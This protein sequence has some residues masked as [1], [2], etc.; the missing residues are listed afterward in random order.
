MRILSFGAGVQTTALLFLYPERYDYVV[1]ADTGGE[2]ESTYDYINNHILPFCKKHN[3]QFVRV[4]NKYDKTLYEYC[5]DKKI[6][7]SM[8]YRDC[9]SKFK[10]APIRSF[11]RNVLKAHRKNPIFQDIGISYDEFWRSSV[12]N[13]Q[14]IINQYPLVDGKFTRPQLKRIIKILGYPC[15]QKSG[16]WFCPFAKEYPKE[17]L[18]KVIAL[19]ENNRRFPEILLRGMPSKRNKPLREM[20]ILDNPLP[21]NSGNCFI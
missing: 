15:P 10:I 8:K 21:C 7:P 4:F 1:F 16:C 19:E 5:W 2:H 13:V 6:V 18:T 17:K 3:I 9:T 20:T 14:Y 11:V 12:S